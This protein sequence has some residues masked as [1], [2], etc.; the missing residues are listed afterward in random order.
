MKDRKILHQLDIN[1]RQSTSQIS[2][3]IG[4]H[5]NSTNYRIKTLENKHVINGYYTVI[6]SFKLGYEV[7]KFYLNF[8]YT[9]P[10]IENEIIDYFKDSNYVWALYTVDGWFDLDVIF[11]IKNIELAV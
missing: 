10:S 6:D 3:K 8:Q 2:K 7:L 5:K 1:A 9:T 4:L 11:W